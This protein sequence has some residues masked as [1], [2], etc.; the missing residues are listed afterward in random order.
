MKTLLILFAILTIFLSG[1][2][3]SGFIYLSDF[4]L[5][6]DIDFLKTINELDT[7]EKICSYM[8]N[9]FTYEAHYFYAP[10]PYTLWKTGKGDC[11]DF[12]NFARYI[13]NYHNYDTY[14]IH[15]FFKGTSEKHTLAV[16]LENGKYTYSNDCNY[17]PL[18]TS[19]FNEIVSHY[20]NF[21]REYELK[22]Y[23][24]YDYENNLIEKEQK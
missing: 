22:S 6:D 14:Q 23:G 1:C 2:S 18:Y 19:S 13:A 11:Y 15:L 7:P 12:A 3:I 17:Y 4:V 10:D 20:F 9:N 5:P 21:P 8:K 16:Y 24:V